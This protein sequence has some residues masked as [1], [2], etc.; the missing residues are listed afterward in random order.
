MT[1]V[2]GVCGACGRIIRRNSPVPITIVCDCY[3]LCPLCGGQMKPHTPT[4]PPRAYGNEDSF[5]W[6]PLGL[7]EKCGA[8]SETLYVCRNHQPPYYSTRRPVEVELR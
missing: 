7:A 8:T 3:R 2:Y 4:L 5:E 1:F 6:D